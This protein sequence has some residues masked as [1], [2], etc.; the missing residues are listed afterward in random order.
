MIRSIALAAAVL[1]ISAPACRAQVIA[2]EGF[3]Y[4]AGQS[5]SGQNG[6]SG[7][8]GAWT[9]VSGTSQIQAGSLPPA[10]PSAALSE[11]GNSLV[12][13]PI[14]S[15][16]PEDASRTLS[17][18]VTGTAGTSFWVSVV[19]KGAG[20]SGTSAQGALIVSDGAGTGFSITTGAT[21]GGIPPNNPSASSTWSLGDAGTGAAEAKSAISDT[22]QSLLVA[23]VTFG[24]VN[25]TIDLFINPPLTGSPPAS[26]TISLPVPHA[27]TLSTFD[28]DYSSL[29]GSSTSTLFDEI[30]AG[31]TFADVT[32]AA[33]PEPSTLLLAAA[34]GVG[35]IVRRLRFG[36]NPETTPGDSVVCHS[37]V[38]TDSVSSDDWEG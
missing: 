3:N 32:P 34:A 33:V 9:L 21:G 2:Y 8:A 20:L 11:T 16:I 28:V 27:A 14:N 12:A 23:R 15:G 5:L 30:R 1:L 25:D 19:M 4:T 22:L 38:P 37:G 18:P 36:R 29:S 10:A 7:F 17:S 31:N 26:P 13:T 35:L 24:A 6:G